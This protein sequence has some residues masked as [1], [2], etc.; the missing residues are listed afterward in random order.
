SDELFFLPPGHGRPPFLFSFGRAAGEDTSLR[1]PEGCP[2]LARVT[3]GEALIPIGNV[4]GASGNVT[5]RQIQLS[6][7]YLVGGTRIHLNTKVRGHPTRPAKQL[8]R[9]AEGW[10]P[11]PLPPPLRNRTPNSELSLCDSARPRWRSDGTQRAGLRGSRQI[12]LV[13]SKR[14]WLS[15]LRA[16]LPH[17]RD[18]GLLH[19]M[20]AS[21]CRQD[22]WL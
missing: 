6:S 19:T 17:V 7:V 18:E 2:F 10:V 5:G 8:L 20:K 13:A 3:D 12:G 11:V 15:L 9:G 4:T 14:S 16:P 1:S 21:L 22:G